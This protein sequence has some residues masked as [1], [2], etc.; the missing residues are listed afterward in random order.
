MLTWESLHNKFLHG[1]HNVDLR[2]FKILKIWRVYHG[3]GLRLRMTTDLVM[4]STTTCIVK[5]FETRK[6]KIT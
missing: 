1:K 3:S 4:V 6:Y 2:E 5:L